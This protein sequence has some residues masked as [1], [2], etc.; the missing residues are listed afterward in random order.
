M[1]VKPGR[2]PGVSLLDFYGGAP[3]FEDSASERLI[4]LAYFVAWSLR[5]R[6]THPTD[7][8]L[9]ALISL[10][11]ILAIP[12]SQH[13]VIP[14]RRSTVASDADPSSTPWM[15]TRSSHRLS[16]TAR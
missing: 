8:H 6:L 7:A 11:A 9:R 4:Q 12:R 14:R 15:K 13:A 1:T 3:T 2:G 5:R 10:P 16:P